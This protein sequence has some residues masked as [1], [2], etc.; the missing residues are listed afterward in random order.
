MQGAE[1]G[2]TAHRRS[3][4][5]EAPGDFHDRSHNAPV[6]PKAGRR[7][8]GAGRARAPRAS[9]RGRGPR[10][11]LAPGRRHPVRGAACP[12]PPAP[13]NFLRRRPLRPPLPRF[14]HHLLLPP[15]RA[16]PQAADDCCLIEGLVHVSLCP[17]STEQKEPLPSPPGR[18][19]WAQPAPRP[20]SRTYITC[21]LISASVRCQRRRTRRRDARGGGQ[22]TREGGP[23]CP[24]GPARGG[25]VLGPGVPR[26]AFGGAEPRRRGWRSGARPAA[27]RCPAWRRGPHVGQTPPAPSLRAQ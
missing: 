24:G 11:Q 23:H 14:P 13:R 25:A 12:S 3:S 22:R 15:G 21:D 26:G 16:F 20:P 6:L 9:P 10:A 7:G 1:R 8:C 19:P 4:R 27:A 2:A 18:Q 5:L 17:G